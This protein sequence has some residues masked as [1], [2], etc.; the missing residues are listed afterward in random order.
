MAMCAER[1]GTVV[2]E[3]RSRPG[4]EKVR[5]LMHELC[6]VGLDVPS[7]D[8]S[9]EVP[10]PEV[11]GR[12]DALFGSTVLEFKR[13]LQREAKDAESQLTRYLEEKERETGRRYLGIAT[14]GASFVAYQI[15]DGK[16]KKVDDY[17]PRG[18][19][20]RA[21]LEWLD[22]A[23]S[24]RQD[25]SPDPEVIRREFGRGSLSYACS[26]ERLKELW[27][28]TCSIPE[29]ELKKALWSRHLEFVYGT[30]IDPDE[31]FL[32]HTYLTIV[33][34][35]M[36]LRILVSGPI[37]A[38]ELL[39]GTPFT[40]IGL[41]GAVEADF[42]DWVLLAGD[43]GTDLVERLS[44]QVARFR[45]S[46][47][48]VDV[49]K[50]IYESL[51][52]PEQRHYLGEYYTPDWLAEWICKKAVPNPLST[53][54]FDPSCGS[55]TFLFQAVRRYLAEAEA[56]GVPLQQA[57]E[58][59]TDHVMGLDVHPVAVMFARV[60]Y[61]L[62]IGP[63]RLQARTN[64]IFIN[65][66]LGDALQ[67]DVH[68]FLSEEEVEIAVPGEPPLRFPGAVAG[69][70]NLLNDVLVRM[71]EL[72]DRNRKVRTFESWMNAHTELP[73]QDRKIL[74]ESYEKMRKLHEA[75]RN[76]IWTF[77]VRNLTRPLWMSRPEGRPDVV[78]GNPPWLRFNA[79]SASLKE[80]FRR[81]SKDRALWVGGKVATHQDLSAYFF[82]RCAER[83]LHQGG[84]IAFI[85]PYASLSRAQYK[86][87]RSG[88]Y[89]APRGTDGAIIRFDDVWTFD[90]NVKP[91]F[92]VPSAVIFGHRAPTTATLPKH[93]EAFQGALPSR[94]V[95]AC[96]ATKHLECKN[97]PWPNFADAPGGSIYRDRFRQ[98]ATI[99]PRRL[100]VVNRVE[101]GAFG[102][103][104]AA[105]LVTSRI[106]AQDKK[107][108]RELKPLRGQVESQFLRPLLLGESIAPY[109]ILS[110]LEAVIAWDDKRQTLL[111]SSVALEDGYG[112]L[113]RW[114]GSAERLWEENKSSDMSL[115]GQLDYYGKLGSQFP[116]APVRIV[117]AKSGTNPAAAIVED[118]TCLIDHV[119]YWMP[120]ASRPEAQYLLAILNSDAACRRVRTLQSVGQFGP[121]HFD[122]VMFSLPIPKFQQS[123]ALHRK[124]AELAIEAE[125][126]AV[127]VDL[128]GCRTFQSARKH[129]R[130][131]LAEQ[132]ISNEIDLLVSELLTDTR[133]AGNAVNAEAVG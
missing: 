26:M 28:R 46:E 32:Q 86:G 84:R 12:M 106:G 29:A 90:S 63:E 38:G 3:L 25:L 14:D 36:A 112:H 126:Y 81:A 33:A 102:S 44:Q 132:G 128:E 88:R 71:R 95:S 91:L 48:E 59:C 69:N 22:T 82:A 133:N 117:Y 107:P 50:A 114:L 96:T 85:M 42:F 8:I 100:T 54:V 67:W 122:K 108:W 77:I 18:D 111:D 16:L 94:D 60:T 10:I 70:P 89:I 55:G 120:A 37:P 109:R 45:L 131:G 52:D 65:V 98:G 41:N 40:E 56:A 115:N 80:K 127:Q 11:Q 24:V 75:G 104:P 93:V 78:I 51:I 118:Q 5:A 124:L 101:A 23:V 53:R 6:T 47:I 97:V 68:P 123:E 105:P 103:N 73:E 74:A 43:E 87:F 49:L 121:R 17:Q 13:D 129:I 116:I 125:Q 119:L 99:V 92:P 57:L 15:S 19:D 72:A 31:L 20:P 35:T 7:T 110:Q 27:K 9:L 76:H 4:H 30:L 113:S 39:Q 61:L 1:L 83:Y 66:Y 2:G 79:M 64:K 130:A 21:L 62:A 58:D 34:K